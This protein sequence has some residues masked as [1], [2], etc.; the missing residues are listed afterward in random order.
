MASCAD[1]WHVVSFLTVI[2]QPGVAFPTFGDRGDVRMNCCAFLPASPSSSRCSPHRPGDSTRQ[3]RPFVVSGCSAHIDASSAASPPPRL[4]DAS[5]TRCRI[6]P[7]TLGRWRQTEWCPSR[8][9]GK[10]LF[11]APVRCGMI[12]GAFMLLR[13]RPRVAQACAFCAVRARCSA[14]MV[15]GVG[16]LS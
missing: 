12:S 3:P 1:V 2:G 16:P 7:S 4:P 15:Y 9:I 13:R 10:S 6:C 8:R 14:L 5:W 11:R